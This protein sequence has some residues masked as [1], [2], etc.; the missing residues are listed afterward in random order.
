MHSPLFLLG[1]A[2]LVFGVLVGA[3]GIFFGLRVVTRLLDQPEG[4]KALADGNAALGVMQA[5]CLVSLGLL[6]QPAVQASFD[7]IDLLYRG[8]TL[9]VGMLP[10][11]FLYAVLHTGSAL[12]VGAAVIAIGVKIFSRLTR[13][14]DELEE[15]RKG[16]VAPALALAAVVVVMALLAAPGLRTILDGLLPLPELPRNVVPMAS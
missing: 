6:V 16:N 5:S 15:I 8:Q 11:F 4:D 12:V 7:A 9:A 2:K 13:N 1:F 10:R 14:V 3:F